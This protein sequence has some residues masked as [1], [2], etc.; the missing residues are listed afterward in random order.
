MLLTTGHMQGS[1]G[2]LKHI[3]H[4]SKCPHLLSNKESQPTDSMFKQK[5]FLEKEKRQKCLDDYTFPSHF[6]DLM[7]CWNQEQ[8]QALLTVLTF[9]WVNSRK[10]AARPSSSM[11]LSVF[12]ATFKMWIGSSWTLWITRQTDVFILWYTYWSMSSLREWGCG[13]VCSCYLVVLFTIQNRITSL[14]KGWTWRRRVGEAAQHV[15]YVPE[16]EKKKIKIHIRH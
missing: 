16:T 4:I 9:D 8:I 11:S 15:C 14:W 7:L 6:K 3:C 1:G 10:L 12:I 2:R 5:R 13:G